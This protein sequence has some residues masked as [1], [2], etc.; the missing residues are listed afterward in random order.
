[1]YENHLRTNFNFEREERPRK[2]DYEKE[3]GGRPRTIQR[4]CGKKEWQLTQWGWL[5]L[6]PRKGGKR[7][8][9]NER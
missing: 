6:V 4:F 3:K 9:W 5:L 1:M 2:K 8:Q 7:I